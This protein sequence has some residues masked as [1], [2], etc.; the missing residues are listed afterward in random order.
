MELKDRIIKSCNICGGVG[1]INYELCSCSINFR[2]YNRMISAGFNELTIDLINSND[3]NFPYFESGE[4][5]INFY[6]NNIEDVM[7]NGLSLYIYSSER[8]RGKTTLAHFIAYQIIKN[9]V[10][11]SVYS[12]SRT[13]AFRRSDN[14]I[15]EFKKD[16]KTSSR[17]VLL[18]LDD[19]GNEDRSSNWKKELILNNF[20]SMLHYRRDH[21]LPTIITSNYSPGVISGIYGGMMDSLLEINPDDTIGGI[22]FK[23][24]EVGGAEDLRISLQSKWPDNI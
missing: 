10:H 1:T 24:V 3:Y 11:T 4:N 6:I 13:Y 20:Q 22:L 21:Q 23:S 9:Y 2:T 7:S 17:S 15:E 5:V 19:L 18:V 14:L 12:R 8:A 16:D